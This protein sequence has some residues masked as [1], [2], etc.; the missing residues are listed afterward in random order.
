MRVERD[1]APVDLS[2][3][4]DYAGGDG[5]VEVPTLNEKEQVLEK[6]SST[7]M[8]YEG[9]DGVYTAMGSYQAVMLC[10]FLQN[11]K[12]PAA[13]LEAQF[14]KAA[15]LYLSLE[16]R[17]DQNL[18]DG[19]TDIDQGPAERLQ[20]AS[21]A[22]QKPKSSESLSPSS[23]PAEVS[24]PIAP[25][26]EADD[27]HTVAVSAA[28]GYDAS[29]QPVPESRLALNDSDS[30]QTAAEEEVVERH[31]LT[32]VTVDM[33][34]NQPIDPLENV[35]SAEPQPLPA[36]FVERGPVTDTEM[37]STVKVESS[38]EPT[39]V[40]TVEVQP[41]VEIRSDSEPEHQ[42]L[43]ESVETGPAE[44]QG[45]IEQEALPDDPSHLFDAAEAPPID[46]TEDS[47]TETFIAAPPL[48]AEAIGPLLADLRQ[49]VDTEA[50][51]T[52]GSF[53]EANIDHEVADG[54][55]AETVA[56]LFRCVEAQLARLSTDE[57]ADILS[58]RSELPSGIETA[59]CDL[60]EAVGFENA[61]LALK[62]YIE[63]Y[64]V[65]E[66]LDSISEMPGG[67]KK[68]PVTPGYEKLAKFVM[69]KT[70]TYSS[71][72]SGRRPLVATS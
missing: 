1:Y 7:P 3:T 40:P 16:T 57:Y 64:G 25:A 43:H 62:V 29:P 2:E 58:G 35:V 65:P 56:P 66:L 23:L 9:K 5:G 4:I 71:A 50:P 59:L 48:T 27:D 72:I 53:I 67:T 8:A 51:N 30:L 54:D 10:E 19:K 14:E 63:K 15:V 24:E 41:S 44:A 55:S 70:T 60:L 52:T 69:Q 12:L 26:V 21:E 46:E 45:V 39:E 32:S 18:I 13:Y 61:E 33:P 47:D 49:L 28:A 17:P 68:Q 6:F 34:D 37:H 38:P 31:D 20:V 22:V 11:D 42:Q 36:K